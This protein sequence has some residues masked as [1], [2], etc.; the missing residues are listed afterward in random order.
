MMVYNKSSQKELSQRKLEA[1]EKYCK[2]IQWGRQEPIKFTERFA[3][4]ELLDI[5]KY[6]IYQ[7]WYRDFVLWLESRNAGKTFQLAIYPTIR[8]VLIPYHITYY[9]GN[10]GEQAKETFKK[11]EKIVK[12]EIESIVGS[13]EFFL[14]EIR[15]PTNSDGF[16]HDP[17]SFR[18]EFFNG[19]AIYTLNSDIV[20]IKGR[21]ANLVCYDE[22]GWFS[23]ELFVQSEQFVNQDENFKTGS[24][25]D[26]RLEPKSFSRQ[27]L[28]ASSASDTSSGFY[29]KYKQFSEQ[30]LL[31]NPKY[32]VCD[33]N[34]DVIMT[35]TKDGEPYTPLISKDKVDQAMAT[36]REKALRELYN[37][38]S[39]DSH[40]GQIV[41]RRDI[42]Q[43]SVK[44]PPKLHGDGTELWIAAYDSARMTDNSILGWAELRN[45]PEKGWCM[46]I[47]NVISMV[48]TKTK[49]KTPLRLPEQVEVF[50][51]SILDYNASSL[52]KL[53][54]ENIKVI[55]C[56]AGAGGQMIG[57]ITDQMLAD[58]T[59][60]DGK[61]HHGLIDKSHRANETAIRAYP[62]AVDLIKLVEP[63]ANRND[64]FD[65]ADKMTKLGVV[66]FPESTDG[67]DHI[68]TIDDEGNEVRYDL[69]PEEQMALAQIELM[70][71]EIVTMCKYE[72]AGAITYNYP[73]DKRN[74][75]HD[76]RAFV[77]GLLCWYLSRLRRGQILEHKPEGNSNIFSTI[78]VRPPVIREKRW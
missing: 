45:D 73:P 60:P 53:D 19:S 62:N 47:Q 3:K 44:R 58:W 55:L 71:S 69:S 5:Q 23:D 21:R 27:L 43:N 72:N 15:K 1:Y 18:C 70:K 30:M 22:A 41:T 37:K 67:K 36:D 64:I 9:L 39:A 38:F 29:A 57:G 35:A 28:Y 10:T 31:G 76:D 56:D 74:K 12:G 63:K 50:K 54:Y 8:S 17:S 13:T 40:E 26:V 16:V 34:V 2:V 25:I 6:A 52:G 42:M 33:F 4:I 46:D 78:Q 51:K 32:F 14:D 20:N 11:M 68:V 59:G 49:K 48:D 66:T 77:Y 61:V 75:M 65:A 24:G 7:S